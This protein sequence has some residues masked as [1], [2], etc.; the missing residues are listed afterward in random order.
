MITALRVILRG[1]SI[2]LI[3]NALYISVGFFDERII[4]FGSE[5]KVVFLTY[6][7]SF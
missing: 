1:L 4:S 6:H 7:E 2:P 3:P 5:G